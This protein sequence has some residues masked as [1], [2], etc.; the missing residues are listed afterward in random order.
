MRPVV[1]IDAGRPGDG[2]REAGGAIATPPARSTA[3]RFG[4]LLERV[5]PKHDA[6]TQGYAAIGPFHGKRVASKTAHVWASYVIPNLI[7]QMIINLP[8]ANRPWTL[9]PVRAGP[10]PGSFGSWA[11]QN[12][13]FPMKGEVAIA[14][15]CRSASSASSCTIG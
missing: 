11:F 7:L 12:R 1:A 6:S 2:G 14:P 5:K 4:S 9:I 15:P 8:L 3:P 13:S 10:R